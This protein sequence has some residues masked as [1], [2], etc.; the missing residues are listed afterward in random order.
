MKNISQYLFIMIC[1]FGSMNILQ[2]QWV[3]VNTTGGSCLAVSGTNIFVAGGSIY[4]STNNGTTWSKPDSGL[5]ALGVNCITISGTNLFVGTTYNGVMLSTNNGTTWQAANTGLP[6]STAVYAIAVSGANVYAGTGGTGVFLSTNNGANWNAVNSGLTNQSVFTLTVS[7][8][9]LLAGGGYGIFL[10]A[11]NGISWTR[12]DSGLANLIVNVL[13]ASGTN[14]YAGS[15]SGVFRSTNG[16]RSWSPLGT[17][18]PQYSMVTAFTISGTNLFAGVYEQGVF[19]STDNGTTWNAANTG[20]SGLIGFQ[21]PFVYA[22][23]SSGTNLFAVING[24]VWRRPL[25]E[26]ITRVDRSSIDEA[27][28]FSLNQNYPNPFNPSTKISFTLPSKSYVSLKV[29]D[30]IGREVA[31]IVSEEMSPGTYTRQWN[32]GTMSS[33][34]YFYRLQAGSFTETKKLILL[35]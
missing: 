22:L 17:G 14:I 7:D 5:I 26:M 11:N 15:D 34:I 25:S 33:G 18:L 20:L 2:A 35:R 23:A 30:L 32:A 8:T 4:L 29:I 10:T 21:S 16:G 9:N 28:H 6:Q 24:T 12:S 13:Y 19:L 3:E 1:S 31:T 27:T